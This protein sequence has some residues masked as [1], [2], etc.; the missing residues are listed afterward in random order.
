MKKRKKKYKVKVKN[1][2]LVLFLIIC[3][4][5]LT[6]SS[7]NIIKWFIDNKKTDDQIKEIIEN[8]EIIETNDNE[9]TEIIEEIEEETEEEETTKNSDYWNYLNMNL[10]YVDFEELKSINNQVKGWI[11]VN[12][13]NINYPFVQTKDN[14]YYLTHSFDKSYNQAGWVFLDYRNNINDLDRN[15]ILYA[16]GRVD[17]TMFGTLRTIFSSKWYQNKDNHVIKMSNEKENSLWQVFSVYRIKTTSDYLQIDFN[18]DEEYLNFLTMLKERSQY[19]FNTTLKENDKII[20][21]S[22]CYNKSD[23]VVMHAKLIKKEAR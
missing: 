18:N 19:T 11:Q 17:S 5:T 8:T 14:K 21:L 22:T 7:V 20:T 1:V 10:I 12:G 15:T 23:K 13:T 3:I 2:I 9:N 6:F 16:H 4:T